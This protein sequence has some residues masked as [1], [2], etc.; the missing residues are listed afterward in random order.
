MPNNGVFRYSEMFFAAVSELNEWVG[1]RAIRRFQWASCMG[2]KMVIYC[3]VSGARMASY[4][5]FLD[6]NLTVYLKFSGPCGDAVL[7]SKALGQGFPVDHFLWLENGE[8]K[9]FALK[10]QGKNSFCLEEIC[11]KTHAYELGCA[12]IGGLISAE[13]SRGVIAFDSL[14]FAHVYWN[15]LPALYQLP[16]LTGSIKREF[17]L[18]SPCFPLGDLS[19][20]FSTDA[21]S[22]QSFPQTQVFAEGERWIKIRYGANLG[23]TYIPLSLT[24]VLLQ[25]FKPTAGGT[26]N[27]KQAKSSSDNKQPVFW[28]SVQRLRRRLLNQREF[29]GAVLNSFFEAF[30]NGTVIVDG[31]SMPSDTV[32]NPWAAGVAGLDLEIQ[33]IVNDLQRNLAGIDFARQII[34]IN[35]LPITEV[36]AMAAVAD[37]YLCHSG[38]QQHKIAWF[39]NVNGII[40]SPLPENVTLSTVKWHGDQ[41]QIATQP[42][43]IPTQWIL[44][45]EQNPQAVKNRNRDYS[46]SHPKMAAK[47]VVAQLKAF[48][49]DAA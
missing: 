5:L 28:V 16:L 8:C 23:S 7:F 20:V 2:A 40:H 34:N 19:H 30:P 35:G 44:L 6:V 47:W 42:K 18:V 33:A 38:T 41:A 27:Y 43:H 12:L 31:F 11:H 22:I 46:I 29:V 4:E 1:H 10:A 32:I 15:L 25:H 48:L 45:S 21:V 14:N 13:C 26:D 3:P 39:Y 9:E 24:R 36:I 37:F 49:N 17:Y